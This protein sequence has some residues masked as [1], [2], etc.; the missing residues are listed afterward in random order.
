MTGS[1]SPSGR[2][3]PAE[4]PDPETPPGLV[5]VSDDLPGIARERAGDDFAY[6]GVDGRRIRK[7]AELKR[8]RSLAVPPAYDDVWI[9]PLP[10]GHLQA[11]G[12]DARG[13]KQYRY[14]PEWRLARDTRKFE[15]MLAFG[16]VLPRIRARVT[17][18]LA[19][20]GDALGRERVLASLVRLLDTTLVR[21]GN[22]EYAKQNRSFGLT[23]LRRR[24]ADVSG[25]VLRLHF[26]GKS[27]KEHELS[28][29]D[30]RVAK[31]VRRCQ[32]IAGQHLFKFKDGDGSVHE[33]NSDDVNRYIREAGSADFTAKDFRTWHG[34]CFAFDLWADQCGLEAKPDAKSGA[35]PHA[36]GRRTANQLLAEV[37]DRLGNTVAVCRKSY[38][39]PRVLETLASTDAALLDALAPKRRTG[40]TAAER[41]LLA[42]LATVDA[43]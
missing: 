41:R 10:D 26:R 38:V 5:W 9:C 33:V 7:A 4:P 32:A 16:A 17:A 42:F 35:K 39:H 24:H 11:T 8:I 22:D 30:P 40:L 15:H 25:N 13:R 28:L 1:G 18:D 2:K 21:V 27:G 43:G 12:R 3:T 36:K 14:H 37:A 6:R 19:E 31:V 23:T 20:P 34:S 29:D